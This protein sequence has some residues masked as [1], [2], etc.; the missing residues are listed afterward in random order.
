MSFQS[1]VSS[2]LHELLGLSEATTVAYVVALGKFIV[3]LLFETVYFIV[4]NISQSLLFCLTSHQLSSTVLLACDVNSLFLFLQT[5]PRKRKTALNWQLRCKTRQASIARVR[6]AKSLPSRC[7]PTRRTRRRRARCK[8]SNSARLTR[9]R[10]AKSSS[11][12]RS[13][14]C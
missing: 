14:A 13:T 2:S 3:L 11:S 6:R 8:N 5:Q 9:P 1:F 12:T 4:C 7:L 10:R